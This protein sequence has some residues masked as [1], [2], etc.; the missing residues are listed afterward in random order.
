MAAATEPEEGPA[1]REAV[2]GK[3]AAAWK[4]NGYCGGGSRMRM[5][6]CPGGSTQKRWGCPQW[7]QWSWTRRLWFALLNGGVP[8]SIMQNKSTLICYGMRREGQN[9]SIINFSKFIFSKMQSVTTHMRFIFSHCQHFWMGWCFDRSKPFVLFAALKWIRLLPKWMLLDWRNAFHMAF[10]A[11]LPGQPT[12]PW[13][14][15]VLYVV[16]KISKQ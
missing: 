10:V 16:S 5:H 11:S 15:T 2:P 3:L 8:P 4:P 14:A 6:S 1:A 12:R 9:E 7:R 13:L